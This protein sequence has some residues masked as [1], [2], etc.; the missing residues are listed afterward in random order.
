MKPLGDRVILK[1]IEAEQ[2]TKTGIIIPDSAKEKPIV[3]VVVAVGPGKC[4]DGKLTPVSVK[5]GDRVIYSKYAGTEV[6]FEDEEYRIVS[7]ADII[8]KVE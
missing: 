2:T 5:E 7:E 1:Q 6:K 4:Q 8:A 3:A